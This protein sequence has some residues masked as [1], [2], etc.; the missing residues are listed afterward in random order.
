MTYISAEVHGHDADQGGERAR[1]SW[2]RW[3]FVMWAGWLGVALV[4]IT[5]IGPQLWSAGI[6]I[7]DSV[8]AAFG[9]EASSARGL[10]SALMD[11]LARID[12]WT[13][14]IIAAVM[15]VTAMAV[16]AALVAGLFWPKKWQTEAGARAFMCLTF[17]RNVLIAATAV[18]GSIVVGALFLSDDRLNGLDPHAQFV[19][20]VEA[21]DFAGVSGALSRAGVT[22]TPGALYVLAQVAAAD[23]D[24][25]LPH[26]F[27]AEAA[28]AATAPDAGFT[29]REDALL[30]IERAA[31]GTPQSPAGWA[32][33]TV[34]GCVLL[35]LASAAALTGAL[36][37]PRKHE[38]RAF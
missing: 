16:M 8:L 31:F 36:R 34:L 2:S 32:W 11:A 9:G 3:L 5:R 10:G 23:T 35:V 26:G 37:T 38:A 25:K 19:R 12:S 30:A 20:Y 21:G 18:S 27:F 13:L 29:P 1:A 6:D 14:M 22:G 7:P 17:T 24:N 33:M 4:V 15:S 28:R